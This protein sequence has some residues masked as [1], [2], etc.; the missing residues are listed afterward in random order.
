LPDAGYKECTIEAADLLKGV[1]LCEVL[2][3][4]VMTSHWNTN[5]LYSHIKKR[6][7]TVVWAIWCC[8]FTLL[9]YIGMNCL[10]CLMCVA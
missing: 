3:F 10:L 5:G 6:M 7:C 8:L 9:L 1:C 4:Y 2:P